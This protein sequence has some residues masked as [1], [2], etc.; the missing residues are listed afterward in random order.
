MAGADRP[1]ATHTGDLNVRGRHFNPDGYTVDPRLVASMKCGLNPRHHTQTSDGPPPLRSIAV[2]TAVMRRAVGT[3]TS[4]QLSGICVVNRIIQAYRTEG[5]IVDATRHPRRRVTTKDEYL[6]I[7]AAVAEQPKTTV[8][9]VHAELGLTHVSATTVKRRLYE[10]GLKSRTAARKPILRAEN[11]AKRLQ[12][13]KDHAHWSAADWKR[14]VFTD[15]SIFPTRVHGRFTA[16]SYCSILEDVVLPFLLGE[17]FPD[18]DFILQRDH[19]SIHTSKLD[20][21]FLQQ[22]RAAV[23]EWPPLSPDQVPEMA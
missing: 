16:E 20:S 18:G 10:A 2:Q 8:R 3:Q 15:E 5:R 19:S 6:Q 22:R 7:V 21:S 9:E 11:K 23:L 14:V 17:A 13:A 12:F 4:Q 1:P